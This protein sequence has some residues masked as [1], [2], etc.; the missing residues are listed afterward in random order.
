MKAVIFD[1]DGVLVD[2]E[3]ISN[4]V[5]AEAVSELGHPITAAEFQ[6]GFIGMSTENITRKI[7]ATLGRAAPEDFG[8]R[9]AA[10]ALAAILAE[11]R[12]V[13]GAVESVERVKAAG[14]AVAVA[15]SSDPRRLTTLL[16]GVGILA[17]VAPH[18]YST[19]LVA[20]GKPAP[21]IYLHA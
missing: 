2:S 7:A 21:D 6:A 4:R 19:A 15:S 20:R 8:A 10:R 9:T 18:A 1:C 17:L 11:L 5:W 12:P 13:P 3:P 16:D 14:R